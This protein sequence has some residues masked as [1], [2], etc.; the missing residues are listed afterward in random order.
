MTADAQRLVIS[1]HVTDAHVGGEL[2]E[3]AGGTLTGALS[4]IWR[5]SPP[6]HLRIVTLPNGGARSRKKLNTEVFCENSSRMVAHPSVIYLDT[7]H[8]IEEW[9]AKTFVAF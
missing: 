6:V 5:G 1:Q 4:L 7:C 3:A 2:A 9:N 8:L